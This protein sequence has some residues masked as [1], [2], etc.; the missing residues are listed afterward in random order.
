MQPAGISSN[1]AVA[2]ASDG[3]PVEDEEETLAQ[4]LPATSR[5]LCGREVPA[6]VE[7]EAA[8]LTALGVVS[9]LIRHE[10]SDA[11]TAR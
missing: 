9:L 8:L 2:D 6:E 10:A 1:K 4:V 11:A 7:L 5:V 3:K